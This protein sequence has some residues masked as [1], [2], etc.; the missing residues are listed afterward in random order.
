MRDRGRLAKLVLALV[1]A[2]LY[3][4]LVF[5]VVASF[6]RNPISTDWQGFT[7]AWYRNAFDDPALRDAVGVSVRLAVGSSLLAVVVGT[8]AAIAARRT[9]VLS[10]IGLSIASARVA[11]PEI[12]IATGLAAALPA[13]GISFGQR[14]MLLAHVAYLSAYVML[15][16]GA[17]AAGSAVSLEEAALD[18]G[19]KRWQVLRD[20][21]IPDLRP[22]IVSSGLLT[23][24]FSFDDVALSLALRGADDTTVPIYIFSA[25]QRRVTPSIHAIGAMI[26]AIGILAFAGAALVNRAITTGHRTAPAPGARHRP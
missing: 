9:R 14:S 15:I 5:L 7:T 3:A 21:V 12:I 23:L 11:T 13:A 22:A 6:N 25:V 2:V 19:A 20:I 1:L 16:V 17:R 18:L 24:A 26:I 8:S 4:P 10:K